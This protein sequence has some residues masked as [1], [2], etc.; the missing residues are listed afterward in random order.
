MV[1]NLSALGVYESK[2]TIKGNFESRAGHCNLRAFEHFGTNLTNKSNSLAL[3]N[4]R[5][6]SPLGEQRLNRWDKRVVQTE[7]IEK[8]IEGGMHF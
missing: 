3:R 6:A 2:N 4:N 8:D 5:T 7:V 1:G